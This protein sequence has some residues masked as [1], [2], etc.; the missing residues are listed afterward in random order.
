M[1]KTVMKAIA[2]R[3]GTYYPLP[4]ALDIAYKLRLNEWQDRRTVELELVGV[5]PATITT[6]E[7]RGIQPWSESEAAAVRAAEQAAERAVQPDTPAPDEAM[8]ARPLKSDAKGVAIAPPESSIS[9]KLDSAPAHIQAQRDSSEIYPPQIYPLAALTPEN[10]KHR[11]AESSPSTRLA[12]VVSS[13][14]VEF[15]YAKRRYKA[16][17]EREE[18]DRQL[19]IE[20]GEG[21]LLVVQLSARKGFLYVPD[22][23][24]EPVDITDLKYFN[25]IRAGLNALEVKQ[26]TQLLIKKDEL[27]AEKDSQIANMKAQI[28]LLEEKI[29][30]LSAEQQQQFADLKSELQSQED[31]IQ[32]QEAH[33]EQLRGQVSSAPV[34][35]PA[36]I[37]KQV[38]D[39]IGDSVWFCLQTASQ[40]DFQ[41]AYKTYQMLDSS[42]PDAHICDYSEAGLRLGLVIAREI[43]T[44]FFTDLSDFGRA[45]GLT[46]IGGVSL[47]AGYHY[48]LDMM[49]A[50]LAEQWRSFPPG[51]LSQQ[52][53]RKGATQKMVKVTAQGLVS[54]AQRALVSEFLAQWEHPMATCLHARGGQ[55]A[56]SL[57][58]ISKL[59]NIAA[60]GE[61]F[62][63][64]W[65]YDLLH[66]L[67]AGKS[68]KGGLLRQIFA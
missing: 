5:R 22:K 53:L 24:P 2:W 44:P 43:L 67:I 50:L 10:T 35:N 30:Q 34:P 25:L 12:D 39:A 33:I 62:L 27:L 56:S 20:N 21:H 61:S 42:G 37:Q 46:E 41:T 54:A 28:E 13:V 58:Q 55:A 18:T 49:P 26:K 17:L 68:G 57:D 40:K 16:T 36:E 59:H 11:A 45:Q 8:P 64:H 47:A 38:R 29:T 51:Q 14:H 4:R 1:T 19:T 6:L 7:H 60:H 15:Y 23:P 66:Q 65:Q 3:W 31:A 52:S 32:G 9:F 48:T 63:Y